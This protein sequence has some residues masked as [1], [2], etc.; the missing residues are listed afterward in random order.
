MPNL[1]APNRWNGWQLDPTTPALVY[2]PYSYQID[3]DRMLSATDLVFWF[4]QIYSKSWPGAVDGFAMAVDE[5]L[6]PQA[7]ICDRR[8]T[9]G[10]TEERS[11]TSESVRKQVEAFMTVPS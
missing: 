5:I 9:N 8:W 3:F 6:A 1:I 7:N 4:I 10:A 2:E 11:F